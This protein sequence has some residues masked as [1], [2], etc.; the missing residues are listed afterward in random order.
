VYLTIFAVL[1]LLAAAIGRVVVWRGVQR[2][3]ESEN[4]P[5]RAR[6]HG[7]ILEIYC[8]APYPPRGADYALVLRFSLTSLP[9]MSTSIQGYRLETV[10]AGK[11]YRSSVMHDAAYWELIRE[12][13]KLDENGHRVVGTDQIVL[14]DFQKLAGGRPLPH[15]RE[16]TAWLAF[17]F[18]NMFERTIDFQPP[19]SFDVHRTYLVLTDASG[20]EHRFSVRPDFSSTGI[21]AQAP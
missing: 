7:R 18:S 12:T 17:L 8:D 3:R 5:S 16:I 21:L 13:T 11:P 4:D 14:E 15:N 2:R 20:K 9:P 6:L 10:C 19:E 1:I